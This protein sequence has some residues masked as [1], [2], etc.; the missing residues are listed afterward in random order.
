M[1]EHME[2]H[3]KVLILIYLNYYANL[4]KLYKLI[5]I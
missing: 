3:E 1:E 4:L 2:T 5:Y